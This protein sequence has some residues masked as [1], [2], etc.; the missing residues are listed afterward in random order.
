MGSKIVKGLLALFLLLGMSGCVHQ[1]LVLPGNDSGWS[2]GGEENAT[3]DVSD[4]NTT[5]QSQQVVPRIPFPVAEYSRLPRTGTATVKGSIYV[6]DA[7]GQ[8]IYG[9]QTRLYLNPVTSYSRQWYRESYLGGKKMAKAD[10]R[11]FNY[12][13]FT[14]SDKTGHF[15]F[16]GV[17]AGSYY[18]IGV[19]RCG[20]ECGY[21]TPQN[22]RVAKEVTV[23]D[24]ATVEVEL[25]KS[26]D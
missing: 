5:V 11:L 26:L 25:S 19:V 22:I 23:G 4:L 21:D 3:V 20:Q 6:V 15:A 17:P 9:K 18:V 13:K 2:S 24:G 10:P 16:Y 14:T 7:M 1:E 12:L 8:K